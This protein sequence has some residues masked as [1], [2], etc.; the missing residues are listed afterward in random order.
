MTDTNKMD[1][2]T[3]KEKKG[4]LGMSNEEFETIIHR[5]Q[6]ELFSDLRSLIFQWKKQESGEKKLMSRLPN[7][8]VVFLDRSDNP[9]DIN[10]GAPYICAV[11]EREREAFAKVVCEEYQPKIFV[12]SSRIPHMVYRDEKGNIR[13][14]APVANSYEE[15]IVAAIKE[16]E[17]LGFPSIKIIFRKNQR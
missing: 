16:M 14:R 10:T 11:Y 7:G 13:R 4:K 8:K 6:D 1:I 17:K 12:P 9:E 15:R 2:D 5:K 3:A